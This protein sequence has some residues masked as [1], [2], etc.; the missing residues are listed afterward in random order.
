MNNKRYQ[1]EANCFV[2]DKSILIEKSKVIWGGKRRMCAD[3][4]TRNK[5]FAPL[6]L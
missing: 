1:V 2:C 4:R 5:G 3:C 6:D